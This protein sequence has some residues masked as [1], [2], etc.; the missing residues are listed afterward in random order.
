MKDIL[1][2]LAEADT[3]E[4]VDKI[5]AERP[6]SFEADPFMRRA[7]NNARK[8]IITLAAEKDKSWKTE[9]N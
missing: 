8:R 3:V 7:A 9:L 2:R 1:I 5:V 6:V 4:E